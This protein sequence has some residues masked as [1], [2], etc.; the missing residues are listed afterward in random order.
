MAAPLSYPLLKPHQKARIN[1]LVAQIKG[2][3]SL[4]QDI[5]FKPIT[6]QSLVGAGGTG[7]AGGMGGTGGI[8]VDGTKG[9]SAFSQ[10]YLSYGGNGGHGG[11]AGHGGT[12]GDGG[13]SG[14]GGGQG[15]AG[16]DADGD[17][18]RPLV[19]E[20]DDGD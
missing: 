14:V 7:G 2:E 4:D 10:N 19:A 3:K 6:A 17:A 1:G 5:N 20:G 8:G 11:D 13:D 16:G 15:A 18:A 12:G 9:A